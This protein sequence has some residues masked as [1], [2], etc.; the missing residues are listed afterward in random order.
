MLAKEWKYC[1]SNIKQS[2]HQTEAI[3]EIV[4]YLII[5]LQGR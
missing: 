4:Q 1:R 3:R 5:M 2:I